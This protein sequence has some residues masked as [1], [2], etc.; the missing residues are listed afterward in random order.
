[1]QSPPQPCSSGDAQ[2]QLQPP[3][4]AR[5]REAAVAAAV[6]EA[7]RAALDE[8]VGNSAPLL[9]AGLDSLGE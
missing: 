2:R 3:Q 4:S 5:L 8:D 9:Q 1:M 7:V 6:A